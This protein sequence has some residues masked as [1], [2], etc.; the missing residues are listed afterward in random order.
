MNHLL[1]IAF[2]E[3]GQQE[4]SGVNH[5]QRILDYASESGISGISTDEVPWCSTF[6]NWVAYKAGL[7]RTNKA[8]ARSWLLVGQNVNDA[9]EPGDIVVFWRESP[10]SWKG[11]VGLFVG[12]SQNLSRVYCLGG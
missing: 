10:E 8:N 12:Y 9:P 5:N 3:I 7:S 6:V 11:H 2:T 1:K 4:V